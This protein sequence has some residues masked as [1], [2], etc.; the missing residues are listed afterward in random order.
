MSNITFTVV[1]ICAKYDEALAFR[2]IVQ[3]QGA[4][5]HE[6]FHSSL[7]YHTLTTKDRNDR[8]FEIQV[9]C[10]R[11][12]AGSVMTAT[13]TISIL[14]P[15]SPDWVFMTGVCA[16]NPRKTVLGD[17]IIAE[18]VI[19]PGYGKIDHTGIHH[20]IRP[21]TIDSYL[22]AAIMETKNALRGSWNQYIVTAR[23]ITRRYQQEVIRELLHKNHPSGVYIPDIMSGIPETFKSKEECYEVLRNLTSTDPPQITHSP[24]GKYVLN[25]EQYEQLTRLIQ[26]T[27]FPKLDTKEP[28]VYSGTLLTD[29]SAVRADI[30]EKQWIQYGEEVGARDLYGL[31]MEGLGLYDAI[32]T[33]NRDRHPKIKFMLVK[34]VS[35]YA[36]RKKDYQFH[37]YGKQASAVFVYEF[38]RRYGY[39]LIH[40]DKED[41]SMDP[42]KKLDNKKQKEN[43]M[44]FRG[45]RNNNLTRIVTHFKGKRLEELSERIN[46]LKGKSSELVLCAIT[47]IAGCGKSELAKAHTWQSLSE[48]QNVFR[49]RLDPDPDS[50]ASNNN[51]TEVSYQQAYSALLYNFGISQI[52]AYETETSEQM[53]QRLVSMIWQE[54]NQYQQ[55]IVI[56]DNAVSYADI[57]KY[58]PIDLK[59]TGQILVT[60][61]NPRFFTGNKEENFSINKGLD[62]N[63]AIRLLQEI[64]CRNDED[65]TISQNIVKKLDYSPLGIRIAGSYISNVEG[66]TFTNYIQILEYDLKEQIL[67]TMGE[68]FIYQAVIDPVR[69]DTLQHTIHLSILKV[70]EYNL[71]L[72]RLLEFCAYLANEDIPF[73]SLLELFKDL[74]QDS[75]LIEGYL[76]AM[77]VGRGTYSLLTYDSETRSCYMHRTTQVMVRKLVPSPLEVINKTINVILKL[78]PYDEYSIAKLKKCQKM[79]PHFLALSQHITVNSEIAKVLIVGHIQLLLTLGQLGHKFSRLSQTLEYLQKAWDLTQ[80][81]PDDNLV[82]QV[83]ILRYLGDTRR[84]MGQFETARRYLN[85]AIEIGQKCYGPDWHLARIYNSLGYI[86]HWDPDATDE[87]SLLAYRQAEQICTESSSTSR[88]SKLQL[89]HS[90]RGIGLCLRNM[91]NFLRGFKYYNQALKLYQEHLGEVHPL[92]AVMYQELGILWS[93]TINVKYNVDV[94]ILGLYS[95]IEHKVDIDIDYS[96]SLRYMEHQLRINIE[97]IGPMSYEVALSYC[98]LSNLLYIGPNEVD[99]NRALECRE[100]EINILTKIL[101]IYFQ[102][103]II[104]YYVKGRI[105]QRLRRYPEARK[106]YQ[107]SLDIGKVHPG[108][109]MNY[110]LESQ[111]LIVLLHQ[112]ITTSTV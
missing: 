77:L 70:R 16:G 38:L 86:L 74:D 76:R 29:V 101:G 105:L 96:T 68:D 53:H 31:E 55:W 50:D 5:E 78:Y 51:A 102:E 3:D 26:D 19:D 46:K 4:I 39:K 108:K 98:W 41:T 95:N 12:Q 75:N 20:D 60:T 67:K 52:R 92:T 43:N 2:Q 27:T 15:L 84:Y 42:K 89:A 54:I 23:P 13:D 49:W 47:G 110:I 7:L 59:T 112:S 6:K 48:S 32:Q 37:E 58:L 63:D 14:N 36:G 56:F 93:Y 40:G 45:K 107:Q 111:R 81:S 85:Q 106:A 18:K 28:E 66:T 72:F 109:R 21:L 1:V 25:S 104:S 88:D 90:Y 87:Q 24:D 22:S 103:L 79:E 91:H 97:T 62:Q 11:N 80:M 8:A 99:W 94:G 17:V 73:E 34:G 57:V 82:I 83:E 65:M 64:S 61:Q 33:L 100:H 35:D 30:D 44:G 9:Y 71:R 69:K 10:P